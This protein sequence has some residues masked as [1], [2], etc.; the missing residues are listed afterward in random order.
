MH[1]SQVIDLGINSK[2]GI[3]VIVGGMPQ[4]LQCVW[5]SGLLNILALLAVP[6]ANSS[7]FVV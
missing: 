4:A 7:S 6:D 3:S 2:D 1:K 5:R